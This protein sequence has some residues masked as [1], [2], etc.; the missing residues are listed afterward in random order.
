MFSLSLVVV[1]NTRTNNEEN[2]YWQKKKENM[3]DQIFL[4]YDIIPWN[5]FCRFFSAEDYFFFVITGGLI[6]GKKE[7]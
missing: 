5:L 7:E 4:L 6:T 1:A 3:F 2:A